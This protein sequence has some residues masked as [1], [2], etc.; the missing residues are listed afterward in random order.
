M[1]GEMECKKILK[2]HFFAGRDAVFC[3]LA[4]QYLVLMW[5]KYSM[6]CFPAFR[7]I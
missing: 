1:R 7:C 2:I 4:E 6:A 3:L 5:R